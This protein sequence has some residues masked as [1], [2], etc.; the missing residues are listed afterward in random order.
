VGFL[1]AMPVAKRA[2]ARATC[3]RVVGF[4][5]SQRSR[6]L[7]RGSVTVSPMIMSGFVQEREITDIH[8]LL[9]NPCHCSIASNRK[10]HHLDPP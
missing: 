5:V 6:E 10:H 7:E 9:P 2:G 8:V 3:V 1:L 4:V